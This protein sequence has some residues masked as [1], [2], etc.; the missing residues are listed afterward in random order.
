MA[1]RETDYE[2]A[3]V[4]TNVILVAN[5]QQSEVGIDCVLA[6]VDALDAVKQNG[7]VALDAGDRIVDEYLHKT[8][9]WASQRTGDAFVKWVHDNRYNKKRCDR[10]ELTPAPDDEQD[11]AEFP[12]A[13]ELSSF[14]RADR[15]FVAAALTHP[16]CPPILQACDTDYLECRE[17]LERAGVRIRFLCPDDIERLYSRRQR[18]A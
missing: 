9:P 5:E 4:D 1:E 2:T 10:V 6:C 12:K 15:V 3:V 17:G 13:E 8:E 14:E 11:F 16:D 7:R 18:N